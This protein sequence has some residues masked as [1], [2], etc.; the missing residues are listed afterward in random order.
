MKAADAEKRRTR[1][2]EGF[3]T[4]G[5][6][7]GTARKLHVGVNTVRKVLRGQP[8]GRDAPGQGG[9]RRASKLDPYREIIQRLVLDDKLTAVLVHGEISALGYTG[10]YTILKQYVRQIRPRS[11]P[12]PTTV[13]EHVP[14]EEGQADWSPY[15]V[16]LGGEQR[17][18]HG[19]SLVLPW[20]RYMVVRFTLDEQLETL[21]QLHE[22]AFLD[23]GAIPRLM[24]YDNMTTVGRHVGP[25]Q[26]WLNPRFEAYAKERGFEI[27][28]IDPGNPNQHA[29]VER[30][31][32]YV[33]G[34]CLLRRRSR[35]ASLEDLQAH[36]RW[37]C[38][39]VANVRDHGTTRE[40]PLDRLARE[41]PLMLPLASAHVEIFRTLARLVG[42]DF[43]VAVDTSRYSVPP[44]F[45]GQ[46]CTVRLHDTKLEILIGGEIVAVHERQHEPR[47]RH[48][49]PEHE[50]QF[51]H[52]T[53][54]RRLLEQA[55]LRLGNAAR[56]YH[57]GLVAERGR[58]A[59]YHIQRILKL[60]DR[61]G[62]SVVIGAMAQAARYGN[63]SAEAVARVIAGRAV[64]ARNAA[65]RQDVAVPPEAVRRWLEGID[66]EQ[67]DLEDYDRMLDD[68][69]DD[70]DGE[71]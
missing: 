50:Q 23:M 39:Q 52:C 18:V 21:V 58:G 49:L 66:V 28:L 16:E 43:C 14:G 20:S 29:S 40:R 10:G 48:V 6:I 42:R 8:L 44:R 68:E 36:A 69:G 60:A 11:T 9:P 26:V 71:E 15:T 31:F 4:E 5:T 53:P 45:V 33:E 63:Y 54:S 70:T 25:G 17:V 56:D 19:F 55:F 59:G 38:A 30:P 13:V 37:W 35:F 57:Q 64:K 32:G 51:K 61:H 67:R 1:I 34:N 41:K 46:P 62:S 65:G 24:T 7:R 27:K 3:R 47:A 12:K 22:E 2:L